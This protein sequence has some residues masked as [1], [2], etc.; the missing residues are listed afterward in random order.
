MFFVVV[1]PVSSPGLTKNRPQKMVRRTKKKQLN[2]WLWMDSM[3]KCVE[4]P[5]ENFCGFSVFPPLKLS[6]VCIG[7][8]RQLIQ[9]G[10]HLQNR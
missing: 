10:I 4:N 8:Q 2:L 9:Q 5:H 3:L 1:S 6:S 7:P